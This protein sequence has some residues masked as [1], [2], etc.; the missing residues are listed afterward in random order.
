MQHSCGGYLVT[1]ISGIL[2]FLGSSG[3]TQLSWC[4]PSL[5]L[6]WILLSVT[7][8]LS[9]LY[10]LFGWNLLLL[11]KSLSC[12]VSWSFVRSVMDGLMDSSLDIALQEISDSVDELDE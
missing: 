3:I 10:S 7:A 12:F 2:T 8:E 1:G 11:G 6:T 5:A 4:D 9:G